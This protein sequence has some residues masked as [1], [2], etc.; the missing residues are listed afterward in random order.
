MGL[1]KDQVR[2]GMLIYKDI[3]GAYDSTTG[4]Y[5]GPDGIVDKDQDQVQL[6]HRNKPYGFTVN[7]SAEWKGLSIN[8]QMNASWGGYSFLPGYALKPAYGMEATNMPS[9]WNPDDM[10]VY[11]DI[12][13]AEGNLLMK[14]NRNGSLPNLA[15]A[16]VNSST[17]NFWRISGTRVT[18][19]RLTIA[20][21]IPTAWVKFLGIQS[22]RIN[23]TG[24]NLLSLYNPYPDNFIDPLS[25]NY[26]SYPKLRKWT[27]GVNLSF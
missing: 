8:A 15:Y 22:A 20:Y 21:K 6:S 5:A 1:S 9:F 10:F 12:Y 3:R 17:S 4:T 7:M 23:V 14:E 2:P 24:Q 26:G 13:D 27:I 19:N 11:Q 18:L 16:S 25:S